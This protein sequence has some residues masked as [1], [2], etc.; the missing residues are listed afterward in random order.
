MRYL[1]AAPVEITNHTDSWVLWLSTA[2]AL[3]VSL[4]A[5]GG[6]IWTIVAADN[7][8]KQDRE[9]A[10][11]RAKQDREDAAERSRLDREDAREREFVRWRRE[12][13][14]RLGTEIME[15]TIDA[16]D[17]YNRLTY[18]KKPIAIEDLGQLDRA[19]RRVGTNAASLRLLSAHD[20]AERCAEL[21]NAINNRDLVRA[22]YELNAA[23]RRD[24]TKPDPERPKTADDLSDY[25][26]AVTTKFNDLL[27]AI[28]VAQTQVRKA[29]E[30][31]LGQLNS[32]E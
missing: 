27:D 10:D 4:I 22:M 26:K 17:E 2:S 3:V 15:A 23:F 20:V 6:V 29:I 9:N 25:T 30:D 21:R 28:P 1:V 12:A 11:S 18:S 14:L 16:Q 32:D 8:A 13:I 19:G 5:L 31:E 7:R 24:L